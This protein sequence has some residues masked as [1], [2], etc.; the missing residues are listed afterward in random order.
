MYLDKGQ[1]QVISIHDSTSF[2]LV[3]M[4]NATLKDYYKI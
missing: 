2:L 1:A 3:K 4:L